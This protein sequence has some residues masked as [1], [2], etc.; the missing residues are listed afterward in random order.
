[1]HLS[2]TVKIQFNEKCVIHR[3]AFNRKGVYRQ[4]NFERRIDPKTF[5]C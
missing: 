4:T 3:H 5:V 2:R 1:M